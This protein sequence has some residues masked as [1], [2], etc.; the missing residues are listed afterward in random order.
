MR[1]FA[2]FAL[3]ALWFGFVSLSCKEEESDPNRILPRS[4]LAPPVFV[5]KSSDTARA[6]NGIQPARLRFEGERGI[7]LQWFSGEERI[8]EGYEV[9][10]TTVTSNGTPVNF[11]RIA[12]FE[13]GSQ[14]FQ[15]PSLPDTVYLDK[16]AERGVRYYYRL[17]GYS[18]FGGVSEYSDST[19]QY[20]LGTPASTVSPRDATP[21]RSD[22]VMAF[23]WDLSA[24]QDNG[25]FCCV[26][27]YERIDLDLRAE[28]CV[29]VATK[30]SFIQQ[31]S[32]VVDFKRI[33]S[34]FAGAIGVRTF[35]R[36]ER[37]KE[38]V[39]FVTFHPQGLDRFVGAPSDARVFRIQN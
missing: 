9:W 2:F 34:N 1:N 27:V 8:L 17:R 10:R 26:K 36:L 11:Q 18:R 6:T 15:I 12:R 5:E 32:L 35:K 39:W 22:S 33:S 25:G 7:L 29:A 3:T 30:Q 13:L 23:N 16:T 28:N 31:D 24:P 20:Q 37:G 19:Q 21:L 4:E 14:A 38:Y